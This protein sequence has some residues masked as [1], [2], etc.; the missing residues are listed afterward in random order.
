[1]NAKVGDIIKFALSIDRM[2]SWIILNENESSVTALIIPLGKGQFKKFK[3]ENIPK[4]N[5]RFYELKI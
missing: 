1:M 5:L 2:N 3:P 4:R